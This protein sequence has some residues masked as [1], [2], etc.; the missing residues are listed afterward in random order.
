M[1]GKP[2]LDR[3]VSMRGTSEKMSRENSKKKALAEP[4]HSAKACVLCYPSKAGGDF[5]NLLFTA[6][7][8]TSLFDLQLIDY[9]KD[10]RNSA[11]SDVGDIAI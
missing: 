6:E 3:C 5:L 8:L 7:S 4:D 9:F 11:C 2:N 1:R 10:A